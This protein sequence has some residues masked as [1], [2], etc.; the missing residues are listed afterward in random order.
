M[1]FIPEQQESSKEVPFYED[2]TSIDGWQ[3]QST[4]KT[5]ERLKS[6]LVTSISR[7]GATVSAFQKGSFQAGDKKREGFRI[8]YTVESP[9]G[10]MIPGRIDIAAL[11]VK[12][13]YRTQRT[14]G[15]RCEKSLKMALF[16]L[17]ISV[18]G[19]WF[20]QQLSPGFAGLMPF[21]LMDEK[22]TVSQVWM[23]SRTM[24]NLLP[25]ADADFIDGEA[26]VIN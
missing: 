23:E 5:L 13:E 10:K 26:K 4:E 2:A 15:S 12:N 25:P 21:M 8:F 24:S 20:L 14:Y 1:D 11:P 3:G 16:M 7:L 19:L 18:D 6:D 9:T 22:R 17:K